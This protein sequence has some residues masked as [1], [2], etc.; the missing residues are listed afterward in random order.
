MKISSINRRSFKHIIA[1]VQGTKYAAR[2]GISDK[3]SIEDYQKKVPIIAYSDISR[4]ITEIMNG[5]SNILSNDPVVA[6][7]MTSG[8]TAKSKIIPHTRKS[9]EEY[10]KIERKLFYNFIKKHPLI[11]R[12]KIV[13][14]VGKAKN[15]ETAK[16][17]NVGAISGIMASHIP[18]IFKNCIIGNPQQIDQ[19]DESY[20]LEAISKM[21]KEQDV[22]LILSSSSAYLMDFINIT[23]QSVSSKSIKDIWPNLCLVCYPTGGSA[24]FH[25][26]FLSSLLPS[27][28][29]WDTGFGASEGYLSTSI[30][31]KEPIGIP[32]CL[33]YFLE[34]KRED[35]QVFLLEQVEYNVPYNLIISS[36]N[37]LLRYEMNDIVVFENKNNKK[38]MRYVGRSNYEISIVGERLTENQIIESVRWSQGVTGIKIPEFYFLAPAPRSNP[39]YSYSFIISTDDVRKL[40]DNVVGHFVN[41]VDRKLGEINVNYYNSRK[42][43]KL[44]GFPKIKIISSKEYGFLKNSFYHKSRFNGQGKETRLVQINN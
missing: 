2:Y 25:E 8:T 11:F 18:A 41:L 19:I 23:L 16:G 32:N 35:G 27:V 4:Y 26:E 33:Q 20:R 17:I 38:A 3:M 10:S 43:T 5:K 22:R 15:Y 7:A 9:L 6:F 1:A 21:A 29:T 39:P 37:G 44:L 36:I 13:I 42:I 28:K 24:I 31:V 12:G 14:L 40:R 34:F 30:N